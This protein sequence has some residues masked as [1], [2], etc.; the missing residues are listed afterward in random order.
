MTS[1]P[2]RSAN[3]MAWASARSAFGEKS[4]GKRIFLKAT[5]SPLLEC[6]LRWVRPAYVHALHRSC[7]SGENPVLIG[8]SVQRLSDVARRSFAELAKN[9][10]ARLKQLSYWHPIR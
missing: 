1:P 4:V 6:Q 2:S 9:S 10:R 8:V 7:Y 3:W 5:M